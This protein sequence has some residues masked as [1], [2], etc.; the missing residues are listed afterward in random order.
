M[1]DFER[2]IANVL[3]SI[4]KELWTNS[5]NGNLSQNVRF[6]DL[7]K[8]KITLTDN[9]DF[10]LYKI[11]GPES[12]IEMMTVNDATGKYSEAVDLISRCIELDMSRMDG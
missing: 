1:S 3:M 9:A 8:Y 10:V 6:G 2:I 4:L 7:Y 11:I 5:G 12:D